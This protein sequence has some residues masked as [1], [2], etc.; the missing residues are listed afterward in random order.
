MS[1]DGLAEFLAARIS[2]DEAVANAGARRVGMPWRAGPQRGTPGGL[3]LDELGLVGSTGGRYAADH[4]ARHDPARAL[5]EADAKRALLAG[6]GG[7]HRCDWGEHR[8]GDFGPCSTQL[9]LGVIYSDHPDFC[10]DWKQA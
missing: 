9:I 10:A 1:T 8:G 3:V 4:I 6:H 2:E 7:V 5:R